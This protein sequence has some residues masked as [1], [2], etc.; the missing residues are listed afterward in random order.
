MLPPSPDSRFP[1]RTLSC[2]ATR[3]VSHTLF[4]LI[5][6][7]ELPLHGKVE[8]A[9]ALDTLLLHVADHAL[10]HCLWVRRM[11]C[12]EIFCVRYD[13]NGRKRKWEGETN[14]LLGLL[15]VVHK[16]HGREG[17]EGGAQEGELRRAGHG[18]GGIGWLDG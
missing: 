5:L 4:L 16:S 15:L 10:V 1:S 3:T 9:L 6:G 7:L 18:V 8:L 17:E 2:F 12:Q 14:G 11:E 13:K